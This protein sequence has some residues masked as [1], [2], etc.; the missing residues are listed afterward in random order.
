MYLK[1]NL[2]M[3]LQGYDF[4]LKVYCPYL[5][6]IHKRRPHKIDSLLPLTA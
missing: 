1:L 3:K 6:V 2:F 5:G 4:A